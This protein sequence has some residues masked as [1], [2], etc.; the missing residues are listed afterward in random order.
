MGGL[1]E[2]KNLK[3]KYNIQT[4]SDLPGDSD[5]RSVFELSVPVGDNC[6]DDGLSFI[7]DEC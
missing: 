6:I 7:E 3:S 5:S 1:W 2:V 4:I